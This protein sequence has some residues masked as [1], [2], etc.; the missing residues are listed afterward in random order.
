M[1][2]T[3]V[4]PPGW[5]QMPLADQ[6]ALP[7]KDRRVVGWLIVTGRLR[8]SPDYLVACRPC[9][10]DRVPSR[11]RRFDPRVARDSLRCSRRSLIRS[12]PVKPG[13][14][15]NSPVDR[16]AETATPRSMPTTWPLPGAGTGPGITAKAIC[17]RPARSIVTR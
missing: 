9:L 4:G 11:P 8:P 17:E 14:R 3:R 5:A 2:F 13:Q 1:F 7:L 15:S 6:C 12:R 10:G 16:A